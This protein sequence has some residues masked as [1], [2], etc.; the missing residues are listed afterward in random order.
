MHNVLPRFEVVLLGVGH[1]NAHVL[2]QWRMAPLA[3]AR[4]TCVSNFPVVTYS[5]MLPGVLA[6]QYPPRRMEIDLVRLCAAA[7][8][9]LIVGDVT[10]LDVEQRRLLF[11]DR[12]PLAFDVLSIGIGSTPSRA[13]VTIEGDA[14]LP[15]K[16][17]QTF[18]ARLERRLC[19]RHA[20]RGP[21]PLRVAIVGG[22]AGGIEIAFCLPARIEKLL[23]ERPWELTLVNAHR[24]V[25]SGVAEKTERRIRHKLEQRGARLILG[26]RVTRVTDDG[27]TLDDGQQLPADLIL[28][29]TTAAAPPLLGKLDLPTD[30]EGFLLTQA[31]LQTVAGAP[32]FAV[33]DTGALQ[34]HPLPKSGVYAVRQGPVL[35]ENLQ[36]LLAGRPLQPY[37]PQRGFMKLLNTGDGRALGDWKGRTFEGRWVWKLKDRIDGRFMDMYQDYRPM[38]R[39]EPPPKADAPLTMRCAG[40]GGKVGGQVLSRVLQ[41]LEIPPSAHVL[42]GLEAPDDAALVQP[43]GGRP[44]AVTTDFFAAPL[45]DLYTTGR[46]AALNAA[47]DAF[48]FGARPL[49]ALALATLPPGPANR[50]EE[51]LYELLAGGLDEFRRMNATLVGGHTIEGPEFTIGYTVLADAGASPRRGKGGL[52]AGDRLILTK[53]LGTGVLLAAHRQALCSAKWMQELLKSMLLSNADAASLLDEFDIA[54]VTDVTGF[55]LAGHLL[56][57]LHAGDRSQPEEQ[58]V[59]VTSACGFVVELQLSAIPLLA[60]AAALLASGVES[61]LAPANRAA[62]TEID[63]PPRLYATPQYAAL[64]DPQTS[65]G[66]LLAVAEQHAAAVLARLTEQSDVPAAIIGRVV[67]ERTTR[68]LQLR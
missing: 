33:G 45:D 52:R 8:A 27:L 7:G 6:G 36:R 65:G 16:P 54:A 58:R 68:L 3:D 56:E 34:D 21:Q 23:G 35:W 49:A 39:R 31:T 11:A 41:Q 19:E 18:L 29:A 61:T 5:G 10:G 13:K 47:S 50:Q 38:E 42:L 9:R 1:T 55:G 17:M 25:A 37:K 57:M 26:R 63:A 12:P 44:L 60:G 51:A 59:G 64:F 4:L 40:C 20:L 66:L 24:D 46:I 67:E 48:V 22:G 14:V 28:W 62:E 15:I 2:R 53:P 43:P 30:D 32:I